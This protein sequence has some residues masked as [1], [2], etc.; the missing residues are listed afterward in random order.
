[1]YKVL[2]L[3]IGGTVYYMKNQTP[4]ITS[5]VFLNISPGVVSCGGCGLVSDLGD[6]S[7]A[8]RGHEGGVMNH[9]V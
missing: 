7:A 3:G 1:M 8:R 2:V 6:K 4:V 9:G 5:S